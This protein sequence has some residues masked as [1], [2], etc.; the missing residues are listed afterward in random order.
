MRHHFACARAERNGHAFA[1]LAKERAFRRAV[2]L[3]DPHAR[4][5]LDE[6]DAGLLRG[7]GRVDGHP[8]SRLPD[9][10]LHALWTLSW[11]AQADA[12]VDPVTLHAYY[13]AALPL[14]LLCAGT[15]GDWPL[16]VVDAA[17]AAAARPVL[18]AA[19]AA[20]LLNLAQ[21][22]GPDLIP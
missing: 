17:Q 5:V 14:P 6:L 1:R 2:E 3:L 4:A 8:V 15:V 21:Q 10:G 18:R 13:A 9:A 20:E 12:G 16:A 22:A 11:P 7:S 19:A